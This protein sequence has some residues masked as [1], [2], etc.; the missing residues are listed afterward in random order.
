ML[1][2]Q[3][4]LKSEGIMGVLTDFVVAEASEAKRLGDDRESF[5]GVDAKGIDQVRMGTLYAFLTE[6]EYDPSFLTSDD[7]FAYIAS[8]DGPWVQAIP[9]D[10]VKRLMEMSPVEMQKIGDVWFQTEEFDP[11]YS[12]WSRDDVSEFLSQI[13]QLAT[14]AM[15]EGKSLFMWT[16]L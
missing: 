14:R 5:D 11:K 1:S 4:A 6:T 3:T 10:M 13:Q 7:S 2:L 12:R 8:D 9:A 16:C 15:S